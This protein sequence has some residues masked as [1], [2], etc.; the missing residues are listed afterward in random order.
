MA[1][2]PFPLSDEV[3]ESLNTI[4]SLA[5]QKIAAILQQYLDYKEDNVTIGWAIQKAPPGL[6]E[7]DRVMRVFAWAKKSGLYFEILMEPNGKDIKVSL[8]P[9]SDT[10][11]ID[12]VKKLMDMVPDIK[13]T[14]GYTQNSPSG[15]YKN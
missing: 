8:I 7:K 5:A 9:P 3:R 10:A 1:D 15:T 11:S 13:T 4:G 14:V 12:T 6:P 2:N